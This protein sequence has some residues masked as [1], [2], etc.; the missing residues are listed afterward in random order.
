MSRSGLRVVG[1]EV[2]GMD[3]LEIRMDLMVIGEGEWSWRRM[4]LSK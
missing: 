3:W 4:G 2:K 1:C